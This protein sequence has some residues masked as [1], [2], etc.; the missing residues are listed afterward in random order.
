MTSS[1]SLKHLKSINKWYNRSFE[2][3]KTTICSLNL[4]SAYSR[5]KRWNSLDTSCPKTVSG[6]TLSKLLGCENGQHQQRSRRCNLS[7]GLSTFTVDSSKDSRMWHN[8]STD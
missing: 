4:R 1:F 5:L 2:F 6:W 8:L 3:Y 7:L